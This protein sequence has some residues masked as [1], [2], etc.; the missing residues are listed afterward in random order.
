[1]SAR[2]RSSSL[3]VSRGN[4]RRF[5]IPIPLP[6]N[7]PRSLDIQSRIVARIEALMAEVIRARELFE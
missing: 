4:L 7:P 2:V 1:M 6:D 3:E 5:K